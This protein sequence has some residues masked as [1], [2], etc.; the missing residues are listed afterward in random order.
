MYYICT[1]EF[2]QVFKGIWTHMNADG[3]NN[4]EVV[5]VKTIKST[6]DHGK[7][8]KENFLWICIFNCIV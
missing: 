6:V 1:G 3:N 2:G 4:S 5:A 8:L 7:H